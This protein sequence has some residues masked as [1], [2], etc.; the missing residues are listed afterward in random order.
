MS[1]CTILFLSPQDPEA[2]KAARIGLDYLD[3]MERGHCW[4]EAARDTKKRIWALARR[5]NVRPL[6]DDLEV[7]HPAVSSPPKPGYNTPATVPPGSFDTNAMWG[8]L[9][10]STEEKRLL[11]PDAACGAFMGPDA[12]LFTTHPPAEL[13][14]MY[15]FSDLKAGVGHELNP[16]LSLGAQP[17]VQSRRPKNDTSHNEQ[18]T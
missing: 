7:V 5:W 11:A 2:M 15:G 18:Q 12:A 3:R 14:S 13:G 10:R 6:L 16:W 1:A 9:P 17:C 4:G 8:V